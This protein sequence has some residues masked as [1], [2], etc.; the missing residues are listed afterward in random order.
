VRPGKH[1][2]SGVDARRRRNGHGFGHVEAA[3][4]TGGKRDHLAI[5]CDS[6]NRDAERAA[7]RGEGAAGGGVRVAA[8]GGNERPLWRDGASQ[9]CDE[10]GYCC[11][12]SEAAH[13]VLP[14]P[15]SSEGS[16]L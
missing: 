12:S 1:R 8:T 15:Y 7:R 11:H 5:S 6:T 9:R 3:I 16:T 2:N 14:L 10:Q 4:S 13:A